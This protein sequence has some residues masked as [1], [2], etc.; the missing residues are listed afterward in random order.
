MLKKN[1]EENCLQS[2]KSIYFNS[3]NFKELR[4]VLMFI[5]HLL[6]TQ[7]AV[8]LMNPLIPARVQFIGINVCPSSKNIIFILII[9]FNFNLKT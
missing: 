7:T 4:F 6:G 2:K 3:I 9:N 8:L 1:K 5:G